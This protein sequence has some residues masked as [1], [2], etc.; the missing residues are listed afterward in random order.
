LD[1]AVLTLKR[2]AI[3]NLPATVSSVMTP[4]RQFI[5]SLHRCLCPRFGNYLYV[6]NPTL[7]QFRIPS[8]SSSRRLSST[9]HLRQ[10][11][12]ESISAPD[13]P[14]KEDPKAAYT[15]PLRRVE[16][17]TPN[18]TRPQAWDR[19][20][21]PEVAVF[22]PKL[23]GIERIKDLARRG[24]FPEVFE[25]TKALISK[26]GYK[27]DL[28]LYATLIEACAN[29]PGCLLQGLALS[30]L[31]EMKGR[32]IFPS[33]GVYHSLLKVCFFGQVIQILVLGRIANWGM[34]SC[35]LRRRITLSGHR[36]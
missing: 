33:S 9:S 28:E 29:F 19:R 25:E 18:R 3:C 17:L 21:R 2:S 7:H 1:P 23:E 36:L 22:S 31:E 14:N 26:E 30:L 8:A 15:P 11:E 20:A 34:D 13:G 24:V 12:P 27:P 35:W 32:G 6:S 5:D 10:S 4:R 16:M